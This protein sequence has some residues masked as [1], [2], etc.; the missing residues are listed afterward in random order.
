MGWPWSK[1]ESEKLRETARKYEKLSSELVT[2][3]EELQVEKNSLSE[4]KMEIVPLQKSAFESLEGRS[5]DK[6]LDVV[7]INSGRW[8]GLLCHFQEGIYMVDKGSVDADELAKKYHKLAD[9]AEERE[10]EEE[11]DEDD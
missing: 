11:E 7:D 2:K 3:S 4:R 6:Y 1:K 8:N 9:E 5:N 10:N